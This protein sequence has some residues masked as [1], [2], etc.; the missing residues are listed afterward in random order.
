MTTKKIF[1][2]LLAASL[3]LTVTACGEKAAEPTT[4]PTTEAT[5]E[6]TTVETTEETTEETEPGNPVEKVGGDGWIGMVIIAGVL[7]MLLAGA[8]IF[9]GMSRRG[10]RY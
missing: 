7:T 10:D 5:T 2:L 3:M 8:M 9:R 6:E 4:A 1:A